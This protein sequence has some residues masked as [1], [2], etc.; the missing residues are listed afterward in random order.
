MGQRF[1]VG[2]EEVAES[3]CRDPLASLTHSHQ[4]IRRHRAGERLL[5]ELNSG[6]RP[7]GFVVSPQVKLLWLEH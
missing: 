6:K 2:A 1:A 7:D 3:F 4:R 5:S